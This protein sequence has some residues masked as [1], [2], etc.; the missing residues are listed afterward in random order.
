MSLPHV[1]RLIPWHIGDR[2]DLTLQA[3]RLARKLRVFLAEEPDVTRRQFEE[4]GVDCRDKLILLIPEREDP[5][6]LARVKELL[7]VED[8][9]LVSSGGV[10]CFI[11]PG[12]WL[13][14]EVRAAGGAVAASA[15]ASIFSTMLSLSGIEWTQE[16]GRGSFVIYSG[17]EG[18]ERFL[19]AVRRL[20]PV[21]VFLNVPRLRECLRL[22]E[23][24]LGSR[25][26]TLFFDLTKVPASK[27]PY[28]DR[29]RTLDCRGWLAEVE[30]IDWE[31]VSDVA[32][33]VHPAP[34]DR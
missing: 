14:R 18:R 25:P 28:A 5:A 8:V 24:E 32:L 2:H 30:R 4:L 31:R 1:L 10:P 7:A 6:L 16:H 12:A 19:E 26:V 15:G 21:F 27:F 17:A 3:A 11:D 29:T 23:P 33:M 22:M 9:G 13:V 34:E 20:E